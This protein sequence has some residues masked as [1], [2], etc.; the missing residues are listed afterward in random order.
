MPPSLALFICFVFIVILYRRD[1]AKYAEVSSA[2]WMP[3]LFMLILGSRLPSQ[4]MGI[5]ASNYVQATQ[6]GNWFDRAVYLALSL[7]AVRILVSRSVRWGELLAGNMALTALL[8]LGFLSISWSDFPFISFKRWIRDLGGYLMIVVLITE[9]HPFKAVET[10]LRRL[11]YF[12][13]PLSVVFIKYYPLLGRTYDQWTGQA[14]YSGVTNNKNLLGVLCLISGLFFFWDSLR[15]W[16]SRK[17]RR[18][19][20]I[21]L[22]NFALIGMT[23]WLLQRAQSATANLCLVVGCVI[24]VLGRGSWVRENPKRLKVLIPLALAAYFILDFVFNLPVVVSGLLGRDATFTGRTDLWDY[25]DTVKINP[26]LGTGYESF[27]LGSR[28]QD[29]MAVFQWVPNQA[30]NGYW[31]MY[32]NLGMV[33]LFCLGAFLL[34]SYRRVCRGLDT[35]DASLNAALL[36][37]SLWTI[38]LLYNITEAAFKVHT[39]WFTFLMVN[40][41]FFLEKQPSGARAMAGP[42]NDRKMSR[43][44]PSRRYS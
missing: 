20:Q 18:T 23:L 16:A 1:P 37:L 28:L 26:L 33:G 5:T 12:V 44:V 14:L 41:T 27:W 22:V 24:V 9:A 7:L 2:V 29:A 8:L 15:R 42:R 39:L 4:W 13:I 21:I 43:L 38:L 3:L 40:T 6:E 35:L 36:S 11:C 34:A 10:V 32:L 19:R 31:E 25:L 17:E 30:H